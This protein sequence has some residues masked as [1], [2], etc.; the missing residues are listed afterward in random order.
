MYAIALTLLNYVSYFVLF[1]KKTKQKKTE[2]EQ[3]R[4]TRD[5]NEVLQ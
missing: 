3:L 1:L 2:Q 4:N 5:F